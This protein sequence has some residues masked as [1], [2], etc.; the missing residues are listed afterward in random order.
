ML[1]NIMG[2]NQPIMWYVYIVYIVLGLSDNAV[3]SHVIAKLNADM[4]FST[5]DIEG[6]YAIF[7]PTW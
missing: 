3:E 4:I 5:T 2:Y 7:S 6:N 1:P